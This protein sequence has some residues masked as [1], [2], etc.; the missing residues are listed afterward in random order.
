[1]DLF[2]E[3]SLGDLPEIDPHWDYTGY[4]LLDSQE[5]FEGLVQRLKECKAFAVDL[6]TTGLDA[7]DADI[8]GIS[9]CLEKGKA[10]YV[11]LLGPKGAKVLPKNGFGIASTDPRGSESR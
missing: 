9:F 10:F 8:V 6:E 11:P 1:M 7:R 5:A 4:Q 3:G 2:E